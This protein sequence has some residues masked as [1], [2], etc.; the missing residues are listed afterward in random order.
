MSL[1][2]DFISVLADYLND[3]GLEAL[4]EELFPNQDVESVFYDMYEA[5]MIPEDVM[6]K[7]LKND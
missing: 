6:E 1:K 2:N 7:F 4:F 5:G 3:N